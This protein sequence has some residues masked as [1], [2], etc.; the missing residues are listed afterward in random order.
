MFSKT[1][2]VYIW[3]LRKKLNPEIIETIKWVW[4]KINQ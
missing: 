3:Y 4:Y 1:V 2:D